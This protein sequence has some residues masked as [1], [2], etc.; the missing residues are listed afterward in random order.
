MGHLHESV[1]SVLAQQGDFALCKVLV[2]DDG[3]DDRETLA[4]A[5]P[6]IV[7]KHQSVDLEQ[8]PKLFEVIDPH[9]VSGLQEMTER[10]VSKPASVE[11]CCE[12]VA[13]FAWENVAAQIREVY[14]RIKPDL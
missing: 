11:T 9:D 6:T 5:T 8:R 1:N 13:S 4:A 7:T 12:F 2:V 3:S 10:F 14:R